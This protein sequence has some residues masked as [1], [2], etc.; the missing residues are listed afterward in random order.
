MKIVCLECGR[1]IGEKIPFDDNRTTHTICPECFEKT[2]R[3]REGETENEV[4]PPSQ[5]R[6]TPEVESSGAE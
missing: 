4:F 5:K 6:S 2:N 1:V 3:N